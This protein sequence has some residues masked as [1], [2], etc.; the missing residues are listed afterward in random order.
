MNTHTRNELLAAATVAD[1]R[2]AAL[3]ERDAG[4]DGRFVYS[5]RSTGVYCRPSCGARM[6]RPENV[7]FHDTADA[8]RR[9]GFRPC[10]R[11]RPD[12]APLG[13][14]HAAMVAELCR[15]ID[16]AEQPPT[17]DELARHVQL[18]RYHLHRVFKAVTGLTPKAYAQAQ[19]ARRLRAELNAAAPS[20]TR[21][22]APA[23]TRAHASMP[24]PIGCSA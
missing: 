2:W 4:A 12:A 20:P 3:L 14:Q 7:A 11:C 16:G 18:S 9:A 24:S 15:L 8:A 13:E 17:L 22:T 23:T 19:R 21:S 1:P 6:P 5:V 10:R